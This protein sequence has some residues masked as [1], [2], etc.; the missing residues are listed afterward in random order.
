MAQRPE[1]DA[2]ER[3]Q[4]L[5]AAL[6]DGAHRR[7]GWAELADYL[8]SLPPASFERAVREAPRTPL[9]AAALNQL[10]GMV[11]LAAER[12]GLRAPA[13]THAVPVV[14]APVFASMLASVRLHLLTAT[15]VAL[16]R[17]NLFADASVD[18]RV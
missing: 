18:E 14:D 12:R 8:R 10:A 15:P 5:T 13:W 7:F 1:P 3:F 9:D 11:E 16:R 6:T 4:T 2:T 17:R